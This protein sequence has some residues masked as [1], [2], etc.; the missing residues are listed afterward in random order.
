MRSWI[1]LPFLL[2]SRAGGADCPH[3]DQARED[4]PLREEVD[5]LLRKPPAERLSALLAS[6]RRLPDALAWMPGAPSVRAN[7][8][9][10][11]GDLVYELALRNERGL[12]R[13][14]V[15]HGGLPYRTDHL[16]IRALSEKRDPESFGVLLERFKPRRPLPDSWTRVELAHGIGDYLNDPA[17]G[18]EALELLTFHV[19]LDPDPTV[20]AFASNA[21]AQC[22]DPEV[23]RTLDTSASWDHAAC[24]GPSCK[25][26]DRVSEHSKRAA[27]D[28]R[29]RQAKGR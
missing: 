4:R 24:G 1:A 22:D 15:R 29:K 20:R 23:L 13:D 3:P 5:L 14:A 7:T 9:P 27:E 8:T 19:L 17:F 25:L 21:L 6:S 11:G 28:I 10:S 26:M 18:K 2:L 16:A 12:L